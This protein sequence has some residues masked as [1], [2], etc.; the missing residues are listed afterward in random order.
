MSLMQE[1]TNAEYVLLPYQMRDIERHIHVEA[2]ALIENTTLTS[3]QCLLVSISAE[4]T[5]ESGKLF[6]LPKS[7]WLSLKS[8]RRSQL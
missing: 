2:E 7:Y 8:W 3:H 4:V 5:G 6:L 1:R